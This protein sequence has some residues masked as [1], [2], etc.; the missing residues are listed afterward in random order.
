MILDKIPEDTITEMKMRLMMEAIFNRDSELFQLRLRMQEFANEYNSL[1]CRLASTL[2]EFTSDTPDLDKIIE[3]AKKSGWSSLKQI[4]ETLFFKSVDLT[5]LQE[6]M[7][8][9]IQERADR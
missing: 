9:L 1:T 3:T 4:H 2:T 7:T 6:E 8:E 5:K